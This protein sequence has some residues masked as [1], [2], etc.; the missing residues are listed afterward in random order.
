MTAPVSVAMAV[1]NGLSYLPAQVQSLLDQLQPED[2]LI[3]V[4]DQSTDGSRAWLQSLKDPRLQ[5]M[6]NTENMGVRR[7]FERALAACTRSVIFLCDQDDVWLP[8]KRDAMLKAMQ[9]VPD[10][11]VVISDAQIIDAQGKLLAPSFMATRGGFHGGWWSTLLKNRYLG[12]CMALRRDVVEMGLPIDPRSPMHDMWFGL[13]GARLGRV[14]YLAQPYLQYRRHG[15]NVTRSRHAGLAQMLKWRWDLYR[16][17]SRR[18]SER[19]GL[20]GASR[21]ARGDRERVG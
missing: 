3:V 5:L 12:C 15:R 7:S 20:D 8:G 19:H 10:C 4:D 18:L 14:I 21:D 16:S 6:C 13:L 11:A 1:Y 17:V 9:Q 2:E